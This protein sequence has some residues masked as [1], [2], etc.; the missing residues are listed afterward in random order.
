MAAPDDGP[1][2]IAP[3]KTLP[4][5]AMQFTFS[6]SGGPGGQNVNKT[7]TKATLTVALEDLA[8]VLPGWA[9]HRLVDLAGSK[10]AGDDRIM[11]TADNSRSQLANRRECVDRLRELVV[12]ALARPK[13][14]RPT[15]PSKR[16]KQRRLDEKK[17][18]G[19]LKRERGGGPT[20]S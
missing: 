19:Q 20:S 12:Q 8:Q 18:R 7:S 13:R 17:R 11:I 14:R 6:R 10:V 4:S 1:V 15:R 3:G 16:A 2:E 5:S 9:M